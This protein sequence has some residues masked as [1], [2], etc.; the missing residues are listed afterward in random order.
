M[1][2]DARFS[3]G[4]AVRVTRNV[5]NDGTFPGAERGELLVERGQVG[6]VRDVGTFLQEHIIYSVYFLE[7]G[8]MV[9]CREQELIDASAP[10]VESRFE[11]RD[12]VTPV[13]RLAVKGTVVAEPGALGEVL[14][15]L[16]ESDP[17]LY[18]V[19]FPG[20]TL[21]VPERALQ[22]LAAEVPP[23]TDEEVERFYHA[24]PERFQCGETRTVRHLLITVNEDFAEN[25]RERAW[26]R[27][28]ELVQQLAAQPSG[29][30]AAAE[31]Y[32]ECPSAL[33]GGLVGRVP[34][35]QLHA[36]L[37]S[38]VFAM[39]PGTVVGP[40]ETAMGLHVVYC[41]QIHPPETVP[42]E[43]VRE[44]IRSTLQEQRAREVRRDRAEMATQGGPHDGALD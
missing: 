19:R 21:Q 37:D 33:H 11:V 7:V 29:F 32:S 25:R 30:A 24:H 39:D 42:L 36:E 26:A 40:V 4:D 16:R 6:Y 27:A 13:R 31:R 2:E 18:E 5:R 10:W 14:R 15:V 8:R 43:R 28:Q 35:G 3:V 44:T 34:P 38:V 22:A 9:G 1:L 12:R 20:R 17:P 23:V 41:E